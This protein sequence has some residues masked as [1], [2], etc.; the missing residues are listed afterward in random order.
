MANRR[1]CAT[2]SLMVRRDDGGRETFYDL[3]YDSSNHRAENASAKLRHGAAL[4]PA[5]ASLAPQANEEEHR[6]SP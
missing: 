4:S 3:W 5:D 2:G 1:S 6:D